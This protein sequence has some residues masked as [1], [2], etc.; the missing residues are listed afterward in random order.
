MGCAGD[1]AAVGGGTGAGKTEDGLCEQLMKVNNVSR[2]GVSSDQPVAV[3][4]GLIAQI[5]TLL[6][7]HPRLSDLEIAERLFGSN[8]R[9][10]LVTAACQQMAKRGFI[11]RIKPAEGCILNCS[12]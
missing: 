4:V 1:D 11:K 3:T 9:H 5:V 7:Q 2:D 12:C 8:T 6:R 10:Q